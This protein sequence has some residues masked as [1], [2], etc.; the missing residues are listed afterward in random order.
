MAVKDTTT[1]E[2]K[3]PKP[4]DDYSKTT[5]AQLELFHIL[6]PEQKQH[7][8][9][10]IEIY[11]A[12]PKYH[13]GKQLRKLNTYLDPIERIFK[14]RN[15]EY[16][17]TIKPAYVKTKDG[18]KHFFPGKREELV[19]DALRK[20]A[21]E[22]K[23][24]FLDDMAGVQFTL[25]QL[26]AELKRHGHDYNYTQIKEALYICAETH[27][28]LKSPNGDVLISPIFQTLGL[29]TREELKELGNKTK[30]FVRF[31]PLV[32]QSI[33]NQTYRIYNYAKA[34]S[35]DQSLARWLHKRMSH[36][37]IQA[38]YSDPYKIKLSTILRDSG[39]EAK[40]KFMR[41]AIQDVVEA[42]KE[43][44]SKSV[45]FRYEIQREINKESRKITDAVFTIYPAK[46]FVHDIVKA[47]QR[48]QIIQKQQEKEMNEFRR[49]G[50]KAILKN[51]DSPLNNN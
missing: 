14:F 13:W 25:Y 35:Y 12:I 3:E 42:L 29:R 9:N 19:E 28:E 33:K 4:I 22:G 23:C 49:Q 37:Y 48:M 39:F 10:T 15:Q 45:I 27:I 26:Q 24:I 17:V 36:I 1:P 51:L 41:Q 34:M 43:M 6:E 30:C 11:D 5:P 16:M 44:E 8:S 31:N 2:H 18:F 46:E 50:F 47:N 7:Y 38:H 21:S 32:S 40:K 20:M